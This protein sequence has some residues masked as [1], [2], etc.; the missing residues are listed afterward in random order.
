MKQL[1]D[2]QVSR[3]ISQ[4]PFYARK[5]SLKHVQ[6]QLKKN[7]HTAH[8]AEKYPRFPSEN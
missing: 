5:K 8:S 4:R 1:S 3:G 2:K 6:G 7:S